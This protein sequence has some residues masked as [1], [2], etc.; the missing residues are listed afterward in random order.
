[1]DIYMDTAMD[2]D[3]NMDMDLTSLNKIIK[4][5]N[6]R[7]LFLRLESKAKALKRCKIRFKALALYSF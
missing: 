5:C 4:A 7:N 3:I 1:M 6:P 2:I